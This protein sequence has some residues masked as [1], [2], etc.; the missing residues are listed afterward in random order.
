MSSIRKSKK[1][2]NATCVE[3]ANLLIFISAVNDGYT[4]EEFYKNAVAID[5]LTSTALSRCKFA[6]DKSRSDFEND[7]EYRLA[8][9]KYVAS[10]FRKMKA[11]NEKQIA[12]ILHTLNAAVPEKIKESVKKSE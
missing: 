9:H 10:A 11:D 5:N 4:E 6:F 7:H 2:I 3:L 1:Q 12:E 8:R